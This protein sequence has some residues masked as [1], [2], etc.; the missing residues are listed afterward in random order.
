VEE[1]T[2]EWTC[3]MFRAGGGRRSELN[4]GVSQYTPDNGNELFLE[5]EQLIGAECSMNAP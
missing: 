2:R 3:V 1:C 4:G 5:N